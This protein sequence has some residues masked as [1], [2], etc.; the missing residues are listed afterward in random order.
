LVEHARIEP[1]TSAMPFLLPCPRRS[2]RVRQAACRRGVSA[3]ASAS[4]S[5]RSTPAAAVV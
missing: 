1:A 5:A 2:N 4:G 3:R